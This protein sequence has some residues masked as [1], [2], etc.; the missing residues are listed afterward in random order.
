MLF[1]IYNSQLD[2]CILMTGDM[3]KDNDV[4]DKNFLNFICA[5]KYIKYN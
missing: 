1:K 2:D 5:G 4:S 3:I